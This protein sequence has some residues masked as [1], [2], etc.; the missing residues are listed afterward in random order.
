MGV[1]LSYAEADEAL[2]GQLAQALRERGLDVADPGRD[3]PIGENWALQIGLAL[4]RA[5]AMVVIVTPGALAAKNVNHEIDFALTNEQFENRLIAVLAGVE[6]QPWLYSG[7]E[8][9]K[10]TD[11]VETVANEIAAQLLSPAPA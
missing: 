6:R 5:D 11:S 7:V 3:V 9:V 8:P 2:A 10:L 4:D 1:F